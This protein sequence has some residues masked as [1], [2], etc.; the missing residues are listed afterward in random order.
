MN[1]I[2]LQ[3]LKEYLHDLKKDGGK[4]YNEMHKLY[5]LNGHNWIEETE[6]VK[7][8]VAIINYIKN[9]VPRTRRWNDIKFNTSL[10]ERTSNFFICMF[11]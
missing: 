8:M 9:S 2:Q 1:K 10:L 3:R 7:C 6:T 11:I 4:Y 5:S